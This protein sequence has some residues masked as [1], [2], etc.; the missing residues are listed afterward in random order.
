VSVRT[1]LKS[2]GLDVGSGPASG[3]G[4]KSC[5]AR[6][7]TTSSWPLPSLPSLPLLPPPLLLP[8][9]SAAPKVVSASFC[10]PFPGLKA[11]AGASS[12]AS[13]R[14]KASRRRAGLPLSV[15]PSTPAGHSTSGRS[16]GGDDDDD[17]NDADDAACA[18]DW[19]DPTLP[20]LPPVNTHAGPRS[21]TSK[22][23][24]AVHPP[25]PQ[26]P[27]PLPPP[28][29]QLKTFEG[30]AVVRPV[31]Q[32]PADASRWSQDSYGLAKGQGQRLRVRD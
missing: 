30:R 16:G 19:S 15:A 11:G 20:A 4:S 25:P 8:K 9:P 24:A 28:L 27:P 1:P 32:L 10:E 21:A 2:K 3:A 7:P 12:G 29:P 6:Q 18:C 22:H 31:V 13:A 5:R 26:L 23:A 14:L 17:D